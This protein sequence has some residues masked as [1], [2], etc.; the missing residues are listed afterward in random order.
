MNGLYTE[1]KEMQD[2]VKLL[3]DISLNKTI[4]AEKTKLYPESQLLVNSDRLKHGLDSGTACAFISRMITAVCDV[5]Q[6]YRRTPSGQDRS[7]NKC[8]KLKFDS[9]IRKELVNAASFYFKD[10]KKNDHS[11]VTRAI[12]NKLTALELLFNQIKSN[13]FENV[14]NLKNLTEM[15]LIGFKE[16]EHFKDNPEEFDLLDKKIDKE[17]DPLLYYTH[18]NESNS[19]D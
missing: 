18:E 2:I 16:F 19:D 14:K 9:E 5:E 10:D 17:D 6:C 15:D 13:T 3:R 7:S 8:F 12:G 11:Y 1:F 4:P